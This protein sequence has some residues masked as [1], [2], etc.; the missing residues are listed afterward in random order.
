MK[1]TNFRYAC[2]I[3]DE[4]TNT[5][6]LTGGFLDE[7]GHRVSRYNRNGW[8]S[9]DLPNLNQGRWHHACGTF[10]DSNSN[11]V[12]PEHTKMYLIK[13]YILIYSK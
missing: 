9:P 12:L 3:A 4:V 13:A 1:E 10:V 6:I 7:T 2:A 8:I 11:T 5:V